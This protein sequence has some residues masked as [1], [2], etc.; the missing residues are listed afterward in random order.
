MASERQIAANR[1]NAQ[2]STG[3]KTAVGKAA[4]SLNAITHALTAKTLILPG[5]DRESFDDILAGL[6]EEHETAGPS[7]MM[8]ISE[9]PKPGGSISAPAPF[10]TPTSDSPSSTPRKSP[11]RRKAIRKSRQWWPSP[12]IS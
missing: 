4:S 12:A 8:L 3:P 1:S 5:E 9:R 6:I 11:K 10:R 7:E 2:K